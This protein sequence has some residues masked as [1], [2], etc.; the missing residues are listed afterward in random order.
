MRLFKIAPTLLVISLLSFSGVKVLQPVDNMSSVKF[1]IKNFGINVKGSFTGLKGTIIFDKTNPSDGSMKVSIDANTVNTGNKARDNHLKKEDYFDVNKYP[2]ISFQ[3]SK[4]STSQ[5]A[6][7]FIVSG[8]LTIKGISKDIAIP[9]NL[10]EK[11][12]GLLFTGSFSID[13]QDFMVGE[14]SA[15]LG[16]DVSVQLVVMAK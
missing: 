11:E 10:L 6:G 3:S 8:K 5:T 15:V 13:R 4:I 14:K 12:N 16:D 7:N 2:A 1:S 9:F